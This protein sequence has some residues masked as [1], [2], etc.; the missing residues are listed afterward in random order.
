MGN[1]ASPS[2]YRSDLLPELAIVPCSSTW[3][4]RQSRQT[5]ISSS[6]AQLGGACCLLL[7]GCDRRESP[8]QQAWTQ[9]RQAYRHLR[10]GTTYSL[11]LHGCDT[12]ESHQR[13]PRTQGRRA[14]RHLGPGTI[15]ALHSTRVTGEVHS[16]T[17]HGPK[18]PGTPPPKPAHHL[19]P[20][21][22]RV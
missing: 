19:C 20:S 14:R 12:R 2:N 5:A 17:T 9:G 10:L 13:H 3:P 7:R 16:S 4:T 6:H 15:Y 22:P 1:P 18:A 21:A 11:L 8:Q